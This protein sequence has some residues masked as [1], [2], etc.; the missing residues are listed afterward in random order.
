MRRRLSVLG[1]TMLLD[2]A[3]I[4]TSATGVFAQEEGCQNGQNEAFVNAWLKHDNEEQTLK[5]LDKLVDCEAG[6]PPGEGQ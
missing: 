4:V 3:M 1:T 5:H 2:A 6:Q